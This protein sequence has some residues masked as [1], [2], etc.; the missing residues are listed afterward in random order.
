MRPLWLCFLTCRLEEIIP[1]LSFS[2]NYWKPNEMPESQN[3]KLPGP[4][5]YCCTTMLSIDT[6]T[7]KGVSSPKNVEQYYWKWG[8]WSPRFCFCCICST[9]AG[10]LSIALHAGAQEESE[11]ERIKANRGSRPQ[12][13]GRQLVPCMLQRRAWDWRWKLHPLIFHSSLLACSPE[14]VSQA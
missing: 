4:R 8:V 6:K 11:W 12:S 7:L 10:F 9:P 5:S 2:Q 13:P 3:L 14:Y 1:V